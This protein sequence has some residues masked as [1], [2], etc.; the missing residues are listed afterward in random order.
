MKPK[1]TLILFAVFVA[2]LAVVLLFESKG[3][4]IQAAKEKADLLVDVAS[5][6][7]QKVELKK[8]GAAII[9]QKDDKGDWRI[10]T[11]LEAKADAGEVNGLADGFAQLR[12]ERVVEKEAKDLKTYEIPKREVRLWLKG[13]PTPV[14]IL[15]GIE[16]PIDNALYAKREDDPRVVLVSSSL[17]TTLDKGV[18]DFRE[19]DIFK[20]DAAQVKS[21]R[22][23]SKDI[24]WSALRTD[25]GWSLETPVRA[26]AAKSKIDGLLDSLS[27]L[28][29]KE[30]LSEDKKTED[31]KKFGLEKPACEIALSLPTA[32]KDIIFSIGKSGD[33]S[34]AMTS[35]SN[36]IIAFEGT[37]SADLGR[38][39]DEIREKKVA[40]FYS[41]EANKILVQN[42]RLN[43]TAAKEKVKDAE[44]WVLQTAAKD[45][46]DGA[47]VEALIRK[48]EGLEAAGFV[49]DPK[50]LGD[51]GLDK[52][53][54]EI[55]VWT[56]GS[57]NKITEIALLVGKEDKAKKQVTV[58]NSKLGYLFIVDSAFMQELPKDVKDWK[59]EAAKPESADSAKK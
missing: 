20:F 50:N 49:D 14:K 36:R 45:P 51:F 1:T 43:L 33:K 17:K 44:T 41:W 9:F 12:I 53:G 8:D 39:L 52:P 2:L 35:Q 57:D 31:I 4:K 37:L 26:L 38:K 42:G 48:I 30:F 6:D 56:K 46:A 47:K 22:L 55:R 40:D 59:A 58:K 34:V 54:A 29:A 7:V 23:K 24:S 27:G 28:R 16:N 18:F 13:K 5:A 21:V 15:I 11:P 32:N 19:K 3:K 10:T 25:A